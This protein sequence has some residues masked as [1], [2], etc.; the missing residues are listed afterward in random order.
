MIYRFDR[1]ELDTDAIRLTGDG[2]DIT[3]E[4]Q[5][6][7]LLQFLIENRERVVSK[8]EIIDRVWDGR[9]VSDGT[10]NSRINAVRRALNDD[11]KTQ[12]L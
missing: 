6:F 2:G 9:I 4:P 1:F 11:G 10:L 5:V 7:S 3:V 12:A 8:D